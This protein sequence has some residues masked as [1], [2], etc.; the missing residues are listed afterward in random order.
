MMGKLEWDQE[1]HKVC[2]KRFDDIFELAER[3]FE[4]INIGGLKDGIWLTHVAILWMPYDDRGATMRIESGL[5]SEL[6][7]DTLF[8]VNFQRDTKMAIDLGTNKATSPYL[9]D[10]Y[11][12]VWR[13]PS[14]SDLGQ[15]QHEAQKSPMVFVATGETNDNGEEEYSDES[16]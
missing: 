6:P 16:A 12:I 2:P 3:R 7:V 1:L 8:G 9:G 13:T 4:S 5:S 10:T 15:I 14:N 11:D